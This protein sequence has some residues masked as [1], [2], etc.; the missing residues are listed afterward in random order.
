MKLAT[1]SK[2][3]VPLE[4]DHLIDSMPVMLA[5]NGHAYAARVVRD[6][7]DVGYC[8]VR[9]PLFVIGDSTPKALPSF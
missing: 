3:N 5:Q 1:S 6:F 4:L 9:I 8:Q 7:A 2:E